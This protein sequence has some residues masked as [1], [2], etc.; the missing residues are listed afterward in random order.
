M[1]V[2]FAE[3]V[4]GTNDYNSANPL[5]LLCIYCDNDYVHLFA[6]ILVILL[7]GFFL[8]PIS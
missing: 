4:E 5:H 8:L 2:N 7:T 6:C 1:P 3:F